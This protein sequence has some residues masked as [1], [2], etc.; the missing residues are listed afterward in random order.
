MRIVFLLLVYYSLSVPIG[1]Q[2]LIELKEEFIVEEKSEYTLLD[3]AN[4]IEHQRWSKFLDLETKEV[5]Y[6]RAAVA[7]ILSI[8]IISICCVCALWITQY[9]KQ[10][11]QQLPVPPKAPRQKNIFEEY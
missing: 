2:E 8:I 1:T 10:C 6:K 11:K 3:L 4:A 7:S 5:Q 9:T